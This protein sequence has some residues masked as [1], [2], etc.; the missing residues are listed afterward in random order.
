MFY[1]TF[2]ACKKC[3]DTNKI[4]P[5]I[6]FEE[7]FG[8]RAYYS[9][10]VIYCLETFNPDIITITQESDHTKFRVTKFNINDIYEGTVESMKELLMS[11]PPND[12]YK[13]IFNALDKYFDN[14]NSTTTN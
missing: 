7:I 9:L 11:E 1:I 14:E 13:E 10:G 12:L 2:Y 6:I 5:Y 3:V 4:F 8:K